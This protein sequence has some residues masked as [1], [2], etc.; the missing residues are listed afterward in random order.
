MSILTAQNLSKAFGPV[1]IFEELTFAIPRRARIA[2]VGPNGVGKTTLLRILAGVDEPTR[3][4][5]APAD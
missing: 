3:G 1:D 4:Q 2:I 5:T